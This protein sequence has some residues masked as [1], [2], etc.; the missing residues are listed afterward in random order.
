MP[1]SVKAQR[2]G[3][4]AEIF[5]GYDG[6]PFSIRLW[7]GL[8]WHS[9]PNQAPVC[10]LVFRSAEGLKSLVARPSEVTLGEAFITKE[11][12][13]EGDLFSAFPVAEHIF[14]CPR[15][16]R[17]QLLL[18]LAGIFQEMGEWWKKGE[19]NSVER[20]SLAIS[21]HYD[22]P[23]DFYRPW[24]GESLVYS[25]GYFQSGADSI[26]IAQKNKLELICRKLRLAPFDRFLDIGCGWG[27][28]ILHAAG[29]HGA[30]AHGITLSREQASVAS[31]RIEAAQ[32]TGSCKVELLDYRS[33]PE[34]LGSF[35]KIASVGM[36]EHVG[37]VNLPLYF[38]TVYNLLRPGGTFL[39]HGIACADSAVRRGGTF[40]DK[41]VIPFFRDV[42][43][44]RRPQG[45]SFIDRYVFPDGQLVTLSEAL[46]AAESAGFEVR[47]V[48]SLRE[49]YALT[50]RHWVEGLQRNAGTVLKLVSETTYRIWLL[51]MAGSA[52]AF[53]RGDISVYQTLLCR[54]ERGQSGLPLT[55]SDWYLSSLHSQN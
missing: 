43:K 17:Q 42:L 37:L 31:A 2:V 4:F 19:R 14:R 8:C 6:P 54:P 46:Q 33:A 40:V 55:R 51:Y 20:D 28:L 15:G 10:S 16:R 29:E 34:Q 26:D 35:D 48:E 9:H 52:S 32:L 49:H 30:Q 12:T 24:L 22:Q 5:Q 7:D 36:F 38:R 41:T 45:S 3:I 39:N 50:L 1:Q 13:V 25:C 18:M 21:Y 23:V 11:L 44:L 53:Q 47:D 27:S